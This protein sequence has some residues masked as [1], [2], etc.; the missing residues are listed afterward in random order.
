MSPEKRKQESKYPLSSMIILLEIKKQSEY[1]L[2]M[3]NIKFETSP[4]LISSIA[5]LQ[6]LLYSGVDPNLFPITVPY[7]A[8]QTLS[9]PSAP[10]KTSAA[11]T[12]TTFSFLRLKDLFQYLKEY[13][14]LS[15]AK[16]SKNLVFGD[17]ASPATYVILKE[18]PTTEEDQTGIPFCDPV[19]IMIQKM[20]SYIGLTK[21]NSYFLNTLYWRPPGNRKPTNEEIK[22]CWHYLEQ[23]LA[24]LQPRVIITLGQ[25]PTNALLPQEDSL[26]IRGTL[27]PYKGD[28][29]KDTMIFSS[30]SPA[31]VKQNPSQRKHLWLDLLKLRANID[32]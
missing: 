17:G 2:N 28:A 29:L 11:K 10:R 14:D 23:H 19:G 6:F 21:H 12:S 15:I 25:I 20:L 30:I 5:D 8:P 27:T 31:I 16:T 24:L 9:L 18:T 13:N 32:L 22:S 1:C 26:K 7:I 4:D 3:T